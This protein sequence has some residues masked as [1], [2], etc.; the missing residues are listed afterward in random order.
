MANDK[1]VAFVTVGTTL[2]QA[3]V[4]S[5]TSDEAIQWLTNN[6]FTRLIVQYGKGVP[7]RL[8]APSEQLAVETYDF[9]PSLDADMKAADL[10]ICHAGAGTLMEALRLRKQ[11]LTVVNTLL[12][13]NHQTELAYALQDRK[14]LKVIS[15]PEQLDWSVLQEF[16]PVVWKPGN[17]EDFARILNG[18]LKLGE[19]AGDNSL[20]TKSSKKNT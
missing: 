3:L 17:E 12:M 13:D 18:Y 20:P 5:A 16:E 8:P 14:H 19:E 7:P 9:K 4:D 15:G 10:I 6:G 1:K 11:V 2:F